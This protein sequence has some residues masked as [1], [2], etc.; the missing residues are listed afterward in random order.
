[1]S[2]ASPAATDDHGLVRL[3]L[4]GMIAMAAGLGIGRFVYTPILPVMIGEL[5]L[6][7]G[8]AGLIASANFLGYLGGALIAA[9]P[10]LPGSRRS[11]LVV[12]L[13]A[14]AAALAAMALSV[15]LP[16]FLGLRFIAGA[17]SAFIL[18]FASALVLERLAAAGR[19]S[20][21]ALHFAGVGIGIAASAALVGVMLASGA[22][23]RALWLGGAALSL[24]AVFA[25]AALVPRGMRAPRRIDSAA[26]G[27]RSGLAA[28]ICAYGLF[29]FGYIITATFLVAIVR[30]SPDIAK[31]EPVTWVLFGLTAAPSVA[32]WNWLGSRIGL[33]RA[34]AAACL[35]EAVGVAASVLWVTTAG[36]ILATSLLGG[37]FM[38]LTALGLVAAR[39][40]TPGDPR[41]ALAGMTAAFGIGQI[42]GPTFAG[43]A[44]DMTGSFVAASLTAATAL[45]LGAALVTTIKA[46]SA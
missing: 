12:A 8:T 22:D 38:G 26:P 43:F 30:A 36:L 19:S 1:M 23:W 35:I 37:T 45:V 39:R 24:L 15:A 7:K 34:F 46:P 9:A 4:G 32:L 3:A 13:L 5:G 33:L 20:L 21:S 16:V 2:Q 18:I 40:L 14:N 44:Y 27:G 17:A 42:V 29:G 11:W 25:V 28:V 6:T 31:L 10:R 41:R